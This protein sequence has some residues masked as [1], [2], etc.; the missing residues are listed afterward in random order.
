MYVTKVQTLK[1]IEYCIDMYLARL[2]DTF[3]PPSRELA[4]RNLKD[5]VQRQ[6]YVRVCRDDA[7]KVLAW[8]YADVGQAHH[9]DG[10]IFQQHYYGTSVDG[11][12][13]VRCLELLHDDMVQYA[14][15]E[16]KADYCMS[17]C[18]P[19]DVK[20]TFSRILEKCGWKRHT[21]LAVKKLR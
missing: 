6:R 10:V 19:Q 8:I 5:R 12:M 21:F 13:A 18:G 1:E 11:I 4:I 15:N 17:S 16:T 3:L 9:F 20:Q 14:K 2:N 7:H